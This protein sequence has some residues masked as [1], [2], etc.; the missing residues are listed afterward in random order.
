MMSMT[1]PYKLVKS[2]LS[3]SN[4]HLSEQLSKVIRWGWVMGGVII[5]LLLGLIIELTQ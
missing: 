3:E 4:Q 5:V 2:D 1:L